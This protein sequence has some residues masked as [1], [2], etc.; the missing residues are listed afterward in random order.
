MPRSIGPSA[1]GRH[2]LVDGRRLVVADRTYNVKVSDRRTRLG[3]TVER[4]GSLTLRVPAGCAPDRAEA[5]LRQS[6][7]WIDDK[8]RLRAEHRPAHPVR[9]FK[10]GETFRYLG[11]DYRLLL[12][13]SSESSTP[14]RLFAGRLRLDETLAARPEKARRALI[15]WYRTTGLA[16]SRG[17]LQPWAARMEVPEPDIVVRDVGGRWGTYR[18]GNGGDG[19]QGQMALHW[20]LFQLPAH[21]VDYVIAH[22]LAHIRIPGHGADYWRLL[23]QAVPAYA[24]H[25]AELDDLGRRLWLGETKV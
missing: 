16:W 13:A 17:R 8:L 9:A 15:D 25:K 2:P 7:A 10:D 11:R 22:E 18:S 6:G 5:F 14:V 3:I 23:Q 20:A 19:R 12:V 21:L 4:D 1:A 24:E